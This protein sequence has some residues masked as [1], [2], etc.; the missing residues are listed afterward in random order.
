MSNDQ[1]TTGIEASVAIVLCYA[2]WWVTGLV[3]L[4]VEREHRGI[5]FHA[6]QSVVVFGFLSAAMLALAGPSVV[7]LLVSGS[8]FRALQAF[9]NLIWL[10]TVIIWVALMV[11][12]FRRETWRVPFFSTVADRL[13]ER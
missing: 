2:G 10:G 12:S 1:T 6:A 3:F 5:R 9:A 8:A 11:K 4:L 7:A 13:A